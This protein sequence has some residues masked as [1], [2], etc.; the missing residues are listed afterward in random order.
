MLEQAA[1]KDFKYS[2]SNL[3]SKM[4]PNRIKEIIKEV[5]EILEKEPAVLNFYGDCI[6]C[7]DIHGD[8][9]S[10]VDVIDKFFLLNSYGLIFLGDYV[11]RGRKSIEVLLLILYMK[12]LFPTRV[13]LLR[14]NHE[15]SSPSFT[16][17][18][19][20]RT[21]TFGKTLSSVFDHFPLVC[22]VNET[23]MC[24]H[25]GL[26]DCNIRSLTSKSISDNPIGYQVVWNDFIV[27]AT[28]EA[29]YRGTPFD[30]ALLCK[31]RLNN[32]VKTIIRGHQKITEG[33]V[34]Y[35]MGFLTLS[36]ARILSP[37]KA[38]GICLVEGEHVIPFLL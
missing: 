17:W 5:K 16:K 23:I 6:V 28:T 1:Y 9:D 15:I 24:L 13:I 11:D 33:Y 3:N 14:G 19:P 29:N 22:F 31:F 34:E 4:V 38:A 25:G 8:Y 36:S 2:I 12:K 32:G 27:Y 7:G 37:K 20:W 18:N 26:P 21:T 35:V 10:L 30:E